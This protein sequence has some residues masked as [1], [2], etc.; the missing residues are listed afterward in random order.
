[1]CLPG[2]TVYSNRDA[3]KNEQPLTFTDRLNVLS[4]LLLP[5]PYRCTLVLIKQ[6]K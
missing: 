4:Q 5:R 6:S 1:M 3:N 2:L